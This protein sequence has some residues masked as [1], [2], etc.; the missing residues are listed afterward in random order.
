MFFETTPRLE[1]FETQKL[2]F[3]NNNYRALKVL[4]QIHSNCNSIAFEMVREEN[5]MVVAWMTIFIIICFTIVR[6]TLDF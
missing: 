6:L 3:L 4:D 2:D 1:I 5:F